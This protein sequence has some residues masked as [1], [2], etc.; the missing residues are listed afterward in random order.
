MSLGGGGQ[1]VG[2]ANPGSY[3]GLLDQVVIHHRALSA[4]EVLDRVSRPEAKPADA[5]LVCNFDNGSARDESS[6]GT[7]GVSTGVETG[8]GKVGAAL[9]FRTAAGGGGNAKGGGKDSYVEKSWDTYVPIVTRAMT[10]AGK[11]LFVAGPPD[12]LDEEYAFERMAAKDPAIERELA[13][14]DAALEGQRGAKLWMMNVET[15]EQGGTL[16]LDSPPVWD[17]MVVARG[18]SMSPPWTDASNASGNEEKFLSTAKSAEIRRGV[19]A[20]NFCVS[21]RPLRFISVRLHHPRFSLRARPLGAGPVPARHSRGHGDAAGHVKLLVPLRGNGAANIRI[22]ETSERRPHARRDCFFRPCRGRR[23]GRG[24]L[25]RRVAF[26]PLLD[27]P[28]R[29][30]L[31]KRMLAGDPSSGSSADNGCRRTRPG[32]SGLRSGCASWSRSSRCRRRIRTIP[33]ASSA[34]VPPLRLK[35]SVMRLSLR[36]PRGK[37]FLRHARRSQRRRNVLAQARAFAAPVFGKRPRARRLGRRGTRRRGDRG[38]DA[39]S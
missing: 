36:Q 34:P 7:H 4:N 28:A 8:K 5:A 9:W 31:L 30:E 33:T 3:S 35:F 22:E 1:F 16:E 6:H 23:F 19:N 18:S 37:T 15:G 32:P 12:T 27:S 24:K 39:C 17:G 14:Q 20:E 10:L 25:D 21:L 26:T 13:E 29:Q 38:H 11:N 2:D